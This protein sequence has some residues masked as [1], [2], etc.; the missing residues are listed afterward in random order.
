MKMLG[1]V[2]AQGRLEHLALLGVMAGSTTD[3]TKCSSREHGG[4]VLAALANPQFLRVNEILS[5]PTDL[6]EIESDLGRGNVLGQ[7]VNFVL[8]AI[9]LEGLFVLAVEAD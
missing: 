8:E 5:E 1:P 9:P 6:G 4:R 7:R 2:V 3:P